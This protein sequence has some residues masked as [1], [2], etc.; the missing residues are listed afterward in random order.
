[1]L[2]LLS[3]ISELN[4]VTSH[5]AA[6]SLSSAFVFLSFLHLFFLSL[7][8]LLLI[9]FFIYFIYI[10]HEILLFFVVP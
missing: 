2:S 7:V 8:L 6:L 4:A 3:S 9:L 5:H 10:I 1:M